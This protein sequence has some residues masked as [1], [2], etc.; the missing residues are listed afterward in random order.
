VRIGDATDGNWGINTDPIPIGQK[1][2]F[3]LVCQG[4]SVTL[5][6]NSRTYTA[7]QPS[8][9]GY[10]TATVWGSDPWYTPAQAAVTELC[11]T[12]V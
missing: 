9:R 6:I 1:S 10:G 8:Y 7:T 5:T 4:R 3:R 11:Y 12:A 2:T